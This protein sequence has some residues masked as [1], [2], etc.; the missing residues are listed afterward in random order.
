MSSYPGVTRA[1]SA[2][3]STRLFP[4]RARSAHTPRLDLLVLAT[5]GVC[6]F[7]RWRARVRVEGREI[8]VDGLIGWAEE[9]SHRW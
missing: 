9:F 8:E 5:G 4:A 1:S 3:P 2:T 6:A 7:G